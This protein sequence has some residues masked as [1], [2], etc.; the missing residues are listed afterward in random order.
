MET[1]LLRSCL[2]MPKFNFALRSCPPSYIQPATSAFD[3]LM[4]EC[5]FDLAGGPLSDWAWLKA[6]LPSSLSGLNI[7]SANLHAPAAYISSPAQLGHLIA[8]IMGHPPTPS[9]HLA[10]TVSELASAAKMP[11]WVSVDD[12][13][14]PLRQRSLSPRIDEASY[15]SLLTSAPNTRS[16]ALDFSTA[17]PHA[18]DWLNVVPSSALGLH[19]HDREVRLCLDYWLGL[20][21]SVGALRCPL[22]VGER[23]A[24]PLADHQ[25]GCGG[26]GD[27]INRHDSLRGTLSLAAQSAALA[28]IKEVPSLIPGSSS[29]PADIFLP[30]WCGGT[31]CYPGRLCNFYATVPHPGRCHSFS[32]ACSEG[33][34]GAKDDHPQRGMPVR[35]RSLHPARDGNPGGLE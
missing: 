12:I 1:T 35:G 3:D 14:V 17:L 7:R 22:C 4:Q 15:N 21:M 30:N 6:S 25:M 26:N 23:V 34:R 29:R 18:R 9:I 33:R 28:L 19:H 2:S 8:N 27:R 31:P 20:R 10:N 16:R 11:A 13:D 32:G 24:D 5:L